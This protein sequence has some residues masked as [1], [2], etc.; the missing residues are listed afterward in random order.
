MKVH[1]FVADSAPEAIRVIREQL[2]P[3][4]VV[5]NVRSLPGAGI[6]RLWTRPRIEVLACAP[7]AAAE[8]PPP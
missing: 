2:G 6:S 4:A 5:L 7:P 8:T 3:S 1:T